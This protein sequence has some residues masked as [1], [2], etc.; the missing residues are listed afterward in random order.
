MN[1]AEEEQWLRCSRCAS[2]Y[3]NGWFHP[4]VRCGAI[5]HGVK[6]PAP[7]CERSARSRR[8]GAIALSNKRRGMHAEEWLCHFA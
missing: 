3:L 7:P 4:G 6:Q 1:S 5:C 2:W 8:V